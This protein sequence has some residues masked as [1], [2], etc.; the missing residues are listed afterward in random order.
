MLAVFSVFAVIYLLPAE[1]VA[2]GKSMLAATASASNFYFWRHSGYFDSPT[3]YPLLHTWSLAVEEQ[4]YISFPIFLVLV[5]KFFPTRLRLSVIILFC[6]SLVASAVVVSQNRETAFYMPYTRAWELLLG[7]ILSLQMFPGLQRAWQRNLATFAGMGLIGFSTLHYTEGMLFPGLSA[8]APCVGSALIIGA[9]ESG[10]SSGRKDPLVAPDCVY[11]A[12][13]VLVIFVALAGHSSAEN[14]CLRWRKCHHF[15][16]RRS[17]APQA[18]T[19]H[20]R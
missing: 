10:S 11:R 19:R 3:S 18:S 8:L 4:F 2:Y 5:R 12:D 16:A 14:G 20:D 13:L 1:L 7:T 6:A 17:F 15:T 9:G